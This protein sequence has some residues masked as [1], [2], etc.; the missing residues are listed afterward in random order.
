MFY[1]SEKSSLGMG[2]H[3]NVRSGYFQSAVKPCHYQIQHEIHF[4]IK[5][6]RFENLF[7]PF[8]PRVP[9]VFTYTILPL[10]CA[11]LSYS[12][13]R[14]EPSYFMAILNIPMP[15]FT[16]VLTTGHRS[17]RR[18]P[19]TITFDTL[20]NAPDRLMVYRFTFIFARINVLL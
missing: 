13:N 14:L 12:F 18:H 11:K 19:S 4:Y 8:P 5:P 3:L 20:L 2:S 16:L 1:C 10:Y 15:S 7:L 17:H 9:I 6:T